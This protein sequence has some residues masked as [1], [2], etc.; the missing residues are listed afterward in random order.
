MKWTA[1]GAKA[2]HTIHY[3]PAPMNEIR[4]NVWRISTER[5]HVRHKRV[6]IIKYIQIL[7]FSYKYTQSWSVEMEKKYSEII[8]DRFFLYSR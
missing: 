2:R 6:I 1:T 3:V 8:T 4:M 7:N 5:D